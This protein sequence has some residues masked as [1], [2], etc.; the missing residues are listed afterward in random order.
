MF[1]IFFVDFSD[2]SLKEDDTVVYSWK[3][4]SVEVF[5]QVKWICTC[6]EHDSSCLNVVWNNSTDF[7][8]NSYEISYVLKDVYF[9]CFKKINH[10]DDLKVDKFLHNSSIDLF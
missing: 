5:D 8:D 2:S 3:V 6:S 4:N 7:L 1:L 10:Q 9:I